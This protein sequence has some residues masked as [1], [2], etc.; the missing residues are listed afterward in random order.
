MSATDAPPRATCRMVTTPTRYLLRW[1]TADPELWPELLRD[2]RACFPRHGDAVWRTA[3]KCWS[4]PRKHRRRLERWLDTWFKGDA[5][6]MED[7][8]A[9]DLDADDEPPPKTR[10]RLPA[11]PA[12]PAPLAAA[13]ACLHLL[14]T[15]PPELVRHAHRLAAGAH[16]PDRGG[17]AA[18]MATINAAIE[19][20]RAHQ[21]EN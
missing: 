11:T 8:D 2:F 20:I 19:T 13:Y 15:A 21:E 10:R 6:R 18:R 12:G 17:T 5:L 1:H 14:P 9:G 7:A 16:H 4:V 3:G